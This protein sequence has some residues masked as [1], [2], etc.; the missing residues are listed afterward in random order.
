MC[1]KLLT[2]HSFRILS[3]LITFGDEVLLDQDN[4]GQSQIFSRRNFALQVQEVDPKEFAGETFSVDLGS[5]EEAMNLSQS[6]DPSALQTSTLASSMSNATGSLSVDENILKGSNSDKVR[7]GYTVFV[8][9]SLFPTASNNTTV[10]S[11]IFHLRLSAFDI[12]SQINN[13][14][15]TADTPVC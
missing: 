12:S 9:S 11:V 4:E 5:I 15:R 14:F 7:L 1:Y 6:I 3:S 13:S 8:S 10:A 2:A